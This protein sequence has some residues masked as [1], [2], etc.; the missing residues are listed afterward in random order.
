MIDDPARVVF[1]HSSLGDSR[2]WRRQVQALGTRFD[3]VTPDLPGFG[4]TPMPREPFSFVDEVVPLLPGMLVGNSMGGMI[5]LRTALAHP[6]LV[7]R[8]VLVDAGLPQWQWTEEMRDYWAREE[9]AFDA[10]DLDGATE[11]NMEFWVKPE[12]RDEI[13]P[14]QRHALELQ[15]AH[16]EPEVRWPELPPLT[17]LDVPTL[18]V[19]GDEDKADFIAIARHLA[20]EIPGAELAVIEGAGHLAGVDRPDELNALLLEFLSGD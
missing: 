16:P 12:H 1:L 3:V 19:V 14:L 7:Q 2:L 15:S 5:A 20:E 4:R 17:S 18:V 9:A 11:A 6:G 10:G 13:R 8:L